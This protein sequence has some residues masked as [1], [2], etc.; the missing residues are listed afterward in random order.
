[1]TILLTGSTGYIA[2]RLL[3]V[4]LEAGHHLVCCVRDKQ[5][6]NIENFPVGR[7][8]VVAV[9]FLQP[10]TIKNIPVEIDA[11]YYLIHSMST[12]TGDFSTMESDAAK[13]FSH[14]IDQ[15]NAK[16]VIYLSGIVNE[17]NLS[18]HL[19]SRGNVEKILSKGKCSFNYVEG[20]NY[21]RFGKRF[22]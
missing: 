3:P 5:R 17:E 6:F 19:Q 2:Q 10:A 15:T 11:A 16:Q 18:K 9:D 12:T 4:L 7:V 1:M 22:F 20:R 14:A 8:S 13:N 21:C